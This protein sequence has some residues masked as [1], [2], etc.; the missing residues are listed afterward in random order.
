MVSLGVVVEKE[1]DDAQD[2]LAAG[3]VTA[4]ET[5]ETRIEDRL[6][7][8]GPTPRIS[9][10]EGVMTASAIRK[11]H[12]WDHPFTRTV[13]RLIDRKEVYPRPQAPRYG[14]LCTMPELPEIARST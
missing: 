8:E 1:P 14:M 2:A 11:L 3:G 13:G 6:T 5:R 4:Q 7:V 9:G 12:R 10:A